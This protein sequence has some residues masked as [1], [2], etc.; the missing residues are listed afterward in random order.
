MNK[1]E[2]VVVDYEKIA[3]KLVPLLRVA[4]S[5]GVSPAQISAIKHG[6]TW[7]HVQ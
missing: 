7:R 2:K 6:I 4:R 5:Y 3:R 1:S